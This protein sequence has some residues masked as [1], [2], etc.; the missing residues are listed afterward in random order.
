MNLHCTNESL[1]G[2]AGCEELKSVLLFF[3]F[4]GIVAFHG[5][6]RSFECVKPEHR[7]CYPRGSHAILHLETQ[8][9]LVNRQSHMVWMIASV[10][11]AFLQTCIHSTFVN[12][13]WVS[14][15][16]DSMAS[17]LTI[18]PR[19]ISEDDEGLSLFHSYGW[20]NDHRA[21]I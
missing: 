20:S 14:S 16:W 12:Q 7:A 3:A 8:G 19:T 4:V 2:I 11:V 6:A 18:S 21:L 1:S 17:P 5:T 13:S 15:T 10:V 9:V